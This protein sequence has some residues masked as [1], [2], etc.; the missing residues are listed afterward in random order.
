M[1]FGNHSKPI[2]SDQSLP[3]SAGRIVGQKSHWI[4]STLSCGM[5]FKVEVRPGTKACAA[6]FRN[7]FAL[8]DSL[9]LL[10]QNSAVVGIDSLCAVWMGNF[11]QIP[12]AT[13]IPLSIG[14]HP[15]RCCHNWRADR[16]CNINSLVHPSP[17]PTVARSK[18][19][20]RRPNKPVSRLLF[21]VRQISIRV[22]KRR[23][24]RRNH[25][26]QRRVAQGVVT[27]GSQRSSCH[28]RL[29]LSICRSQVYRLLF[30][31]A[32]GV[33]TLLLLLLNL[34]G[35]S[36]RWRSADF[37]LHRLSIVGGVEIGID[38]WELLRLV[39]RDS[40]RFRSVSWSQRHRICPDRIAR[41]TIF[42]SQPYHFCPQ[43][44]GIR[45]ER[46]SS[47][48]SPRIRLW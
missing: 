19:A 46:F 43:A 32:S 27:I 31:C 13:V 22:G 8:S 25:A 36:S 5:N 9:T 30:R 12:V 40:W 6:H 1:S 26:S 39:A 10:H 38:T 42:L 24:F 7:L 28:H 44:F 34:L 37:I 15:V 33:K 29:R 48:E 4:D 17:A 21:A 3:R 20:L 23:Q 14:N 41:G 2:T 45:V 16:P 47:G 11:H 35:P 18:N